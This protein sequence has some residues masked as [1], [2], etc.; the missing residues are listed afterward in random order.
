MAQVH[1]T[2]T[3]EILKELMLGNWESGVAKLLPK[4]DH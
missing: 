2:L 1:L 3:D 4:I